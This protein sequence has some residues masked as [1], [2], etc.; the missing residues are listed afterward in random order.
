MKTN[1]LK[2]VCVKALEDLSQL[3]DLKQ[4]YEFEHSHQFFQDRVNDDEFRIAVVGEFS[5]GKSTFIN[6]L[7][8]RDILQHASTETTAVLTRIVN[9]T[10]D[11]K[12]CNTGIVK[13]RNGETLPLS[14]ISELRQYTTTSSEHFDVASDIE[15]V[16]I[17]LPFIESK[18]KIVVVDTPGLNGVADGHR[19]QTVEMIQRA[20]ACIYL[21]QRRGLAESDV[22]FLNY[23]KAKQNNFIF[24]QNFIDEIHELEGE[25]VEEKLN[26]QYE[27]LKTHVFNDGYEY[28]YSVCGISALKALVSA[29]TTITRLYSDSTQDL[30]AEDRVLIRKESRFDDFMKLLQDVFEDENVDRIQY[31]GT[32]IAI[33]KWALDL[34]QQVVRN[35]QEIAEIYKASQE[36]HAIEKL[37][38]IKSKL[39]SSIDKRKS[40]LANFVRDSIKRIRDEE[41]QKLQNALGELENCSVA[42]FD[43]LE[44]ATD[45]KKLENLEEKARNLPKKLSN[46]T[47]QFWSVQAERIGDSLQSFYQFLIVRVQQYSGISDEVTASASFDV[48]RPTAQL[49]FKQDESVI[50]SAKKTLSKQEEELREGRKKLSDAETD[51]HVAQSTQE[52]YSKDLQRVKSE[53]QKAESVTYARSKRPNAQRREESYTVYEYRGGLGILDKLLGPKRETRYRTIVDDSAGERWD[54]ERAKAL[55][56][57]TVKQDEMQRQLDEARRRKERYQAEI[58]QQKGQNQA[59]VADIERRRQHIL[60]MEKD[61]ELKKEYALKEYIAEMVSNIKK[62][63]AEYFKQ[64]NVIY[65]NTLEATIAQAHQQFNDIALKLFEEMIQKKLEWIEKSKQES[66]P[67]LRV[68][69]QNMQNTIAKLNDIRN[70]MEVVSNECKQTTI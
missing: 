5:S 58:E 19:E 56:A 32:A 4:L 28:A 35:E 12:Q 30:T 44:G 65:V 38:R 8:G 49:Q 50:A 63:L 7:L 57:Y 34:M 33:Y 51:F 24:V 23:L 21:I 41:K 52:R 1:K 54:A 59:K 9:V 25:S 43:Q 20:H 64:Y 67:V 55:N 40:D 27:I 16:E 68:E 29:D 70:Y 37:D 3:D 17:Y 48:R 26:E 11:S 53:K 2:S 13:L 61:L 22:E 18:H 14:N 62:Q 39:S 6:A 42:E 36:N 15:C 66:S 69:L 47:E 10:S 60:R 31:E 46:D 45:K